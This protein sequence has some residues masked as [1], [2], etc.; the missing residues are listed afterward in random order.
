M[1]PVDSYDMNLDT[2]QMC[3]L[4]QMKPVFPKEHWARAHSGLTVTRIC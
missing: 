4:D 1:V 3:R 2:T